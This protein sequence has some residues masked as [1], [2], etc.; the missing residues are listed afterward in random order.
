MA[1]MTRDERD[2]DLEATADE[3]A[4]RIYRMAPEH[5]Y[6]VDYGKDLGA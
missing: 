2:A 3:D 1:K 5:W 4:P 6:T